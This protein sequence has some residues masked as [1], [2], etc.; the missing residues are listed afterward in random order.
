[1]RLLKGM[2]S[3][4]PNRF[5]I[6]SRGGVLYIGLIDEGKIVD[7]TYLSPDIM[8]QFKDGDTIRIS[9]NSITRIQ[10]AKIQL[11]LNELGKDAIPS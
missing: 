8:R 4:Q 11:A 9:K 10:M 3:N 6:Y 7:R 5:Y 2:K 1:M